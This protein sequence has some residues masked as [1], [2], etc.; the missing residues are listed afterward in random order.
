VGWSDAVQKRDQWR[1]LL[2]SVMHLQVSKTVGKFL[3][4]LADTGF[5]REALLHGIRFQDQ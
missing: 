2:D 5:S 3:A 1:G 4:N